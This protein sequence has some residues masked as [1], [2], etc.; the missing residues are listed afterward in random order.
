MAP[1]P[2]PPYW[3]LVAVLSTSLPMT[4]ALAMRLYEAARELY[5]RDAEVEQVFGDLFTGEVRNLRRD[6]VLGAMV[7]PAFRAELDTGTGHGSVRFLLTRQGLA[8][9]GA[10][11]ASR[12]EA[13]N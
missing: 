4:P 7:G 2:Q 11:A 5:R 9:T 3:L 10:P 13:P 6:V 8:W 1:A 12:A